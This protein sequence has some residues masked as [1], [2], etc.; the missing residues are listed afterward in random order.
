MDLRLRPYAPTDAQALVELFTDTVHAINQRD[1]TQQQCD[2]WAPRAYD[3]TRWQ[4]RFDQ[5]HPLIAEQ[6]SIIVGFGE[7]ESDGHID[8]FYVH[9]NY[10]CQGV[11][12]QLLQALEQQAR[13]SQLARL[14][15]EVSITALPF[16]RRHGF[17]TIAEQSVMVRGVAMT[18]YRVEK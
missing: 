1:Y 12:T 11:G 15:A 7:L 13:A 2:A 16:F 17:H 8:A 6:V 3:L 14:Y 9:A 10:Q 18:N 4:C 5:K